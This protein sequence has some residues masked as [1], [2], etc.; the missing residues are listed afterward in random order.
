MATWKRPDADGSP[1]PFAKRVC[2]ILRSSA[3]APPNPRD[4]G[5]CSH[6]S[7]MLT[8]AVWIRVCPPPPSL[9]SAAL[10]AIVRLITGAA[11]GYGDF[12]RG[13][14]RAREEGVVL[15]RRAC[16]RDAWRGAGLGT[17]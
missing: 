1:G 17:P 16:F 2:A 13:V 14:V 10:E 5:A 9:S 11:S 7:L 15:S 12:E 4:Q 6:T 8:V 3:F